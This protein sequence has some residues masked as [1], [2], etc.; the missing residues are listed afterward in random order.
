MI[1]HELI[2][3]TEEPVGTK[4]AGEMWNAKIDFYME[5]YQRLADQ[6]NRSTKVID[7]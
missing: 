5:F 2:K 4:T 6:L 1:R 3:A 7:D